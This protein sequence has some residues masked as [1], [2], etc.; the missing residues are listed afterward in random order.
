MISALTYFII[1]S[2]VIIPGFGGSGSSLP[3]LRASDVICFAVFIFLS[4]TQFRSIGRLLFSRHLRAIS[5]P[6]AF[7]LAYLIALTALLRGMFVVQMDSA[8]LGQCLVAVI[9]KARPWFIPICLFSMLTTRRRLQGSATLFIGL[10]FVEFAIMAMQSTD[11]LGINSWLTPLYFGETEAR[12]LAGGRVCGTMSNP[13]DAGTLLTVLGILA[14]SRAYLGRDKNLNLRAIL[15]A[16]L[17]L[18]G[19]VLF[20]K[21]RQGTLC[22]LL[23]MAIVQVA[24]LLLGRRW[25]KGQWALLAVM[26]AFLGLVGHG[27]TSQIL[28]ERFGFFFGEQRITEVSSVSTRLENWRRIPEVDGAW[29]LSGRG[30]TVAETWD[31]EYF[32]T[33]RFVGIPGLLGLLGMFILPGAAAWRRAKAIGPQH[34]DAWVHVGGAACSIALLATMTVNGTWNSMTIMPTLMIALVL[35]PA[36]MR[37]EDEESARRGPGAPSRGARRA[38]AFA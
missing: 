29:M 13:N 12:V 26:L 14:Y 15:A 10:V 16:L 3:Y 20:C 32:N 8:T 25:G 22:L 4:A 21:S 2:A 24:T 35:S 36:A 33:L 37:L 9:G 38:G 30:Y 27:R 23:G 5:I 34:E 17:A 18:T 6:Y 7:L 11:M 1:V 19:C 31:S 28:A